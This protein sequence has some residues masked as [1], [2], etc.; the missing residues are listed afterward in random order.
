MNW[1]LRKMYALAYWLCDKTA[2]SE[3][4]VFK[5]F[6]TRFKKPNE[7]KD[8]DLDKELKRLLNEALKD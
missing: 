2:P 8:E 6:Y 4:H 3:A 7:V 5:G 1:I